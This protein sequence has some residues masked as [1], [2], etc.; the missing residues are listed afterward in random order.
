M[1]NQI[2]RGLQGIGTD[3]LEIDRFRKAVDRY[4]DRFLTRLFTSK[5][6][7]HCAQYKDPI[8]RFAVRFAAKEAVVKALGV[9]FGKDLSFQDIEILNDTS[10]KPH[11]FLSPTASAHFG[12]PSFLLSLSHSRNYATAVA[13]SLS[14]PTS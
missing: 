9:G 5:E 7:A 13:L 1:T 3:I 12:H 8:P 6:R 2:N 4:G 11:V 10:G 14:S